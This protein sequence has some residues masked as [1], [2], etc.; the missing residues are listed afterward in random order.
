MQR[1]APNTY[2]SDFPDVIKN[3][4]LQRKRLT[5]SEKTIRFRQPD[6]RSGSKVNQ[7]IMSQHLSTRNISSKSMHAFLSNLTNRQMTHRQT[8][9]RGQT[10]LPPPLSEVTRLWETGPAQSPPRC[11]K[12][13]SP[14]I[15][16]QCTN[17]LSFDVAL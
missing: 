11:T 1:R 6:S 4:A 12:C 2:T 16:G 3:S 8:D 14:P 7:F 10:H 9:K 15:N 5:I 17:F 13:N